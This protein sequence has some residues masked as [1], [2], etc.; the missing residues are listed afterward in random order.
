[1]AAWPRHISR[2]SWYVTVRVTD[3]QHEVLPVPYFSL[4]S[5]AAR[6]DPVSAQRKR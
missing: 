6:I 2:V 5:S 3:W 4:N 1:M